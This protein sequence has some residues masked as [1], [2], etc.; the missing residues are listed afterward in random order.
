ME[1]IDVD[2]VDVEAVEVVVVLLNS[3]TIGST[4]TVKVTVHAVAFTVNGVIAIQ[5]PFL[6]M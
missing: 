4:G 6:S 3:A 2:I 5:A 1:A